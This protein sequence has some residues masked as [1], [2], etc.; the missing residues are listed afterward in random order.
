[1]LWTDEDNFDNTLAFQLLFLAFF[2]NGEPYGYKR[3]VLLK[4]LYYRYGSGSDWRSVLG[5]SYSL[6]KLEC[7]IWTF[8]STNCLSRLM[9]LREKEEQILYSITDVLHRLMEWFKKNVASARSPRSPDLETMDFSIIGFMKSEVY[10]LTVVNSEE[11]ILNRIVVSA[12]KVRGTF[13]FKVNVKVMRKRLEA[14][15]RKSG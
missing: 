3:K 13:S 4:E 12:N 6:G 15:V 5:T 2:G 14:C 9:K 1:M 7:L 10:N 11:D 8:F